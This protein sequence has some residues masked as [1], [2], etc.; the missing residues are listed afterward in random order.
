MH[1][2]AKGRISEMKDKNLEAAMQ[3]V[4]NTIRLFNDPAVR[5]YYVSIAEKLGTHQA[6]NE[7]KSLTYIG[8]SHLNAIRAN[9]RGAVV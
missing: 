2:A 3:N 5:G 1:G 4:T 7:I 8:K 6:I 9:Q